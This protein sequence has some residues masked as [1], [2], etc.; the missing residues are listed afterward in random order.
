MVFGAR[1]LTFLAVIASF[2]PSTVFAHA[3]LVSQTPAADVTVTPAPSKLTLSFSEGVEPG[4]SG[5]TLN[6]PQQQKPAT[7]KVQLA[8][9][10]AKT[11]I[12]PLETVLTAGDWRVDWHVVSVDGHKTHGSY[13]FH[14]K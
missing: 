11:L 3:H 1:Q 12:V 2:T 6:G 4:F 7:G 9:G 10:N 8:A 14:V 13:R 5:V